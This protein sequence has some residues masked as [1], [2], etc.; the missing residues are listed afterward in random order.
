[1]NIYFV[2]FKAIPP[3]YSTLVTTFFP[4]LE[5]LQKFIF[6]DLVQLLLQCR[7]SAKIEDEPK[8]VQAKQLSKINC[9]FKMAA[10]VGINEKH[11]YQHNATKN[12]KLEYT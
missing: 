8:H 9:S 4:I 12:S 1:M 10:L 11:K 6:C 5:A 7:L 2:P 3:T